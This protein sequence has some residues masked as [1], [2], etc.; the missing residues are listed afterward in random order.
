MEQ[1]V[2]AQCAKAKQTPATVERLILDHCVASRL[3]EL[4]QCTNLLNL[5]IINAGLHSL[6]GFP[7]LPR[8]RTVRQHVT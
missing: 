2:L 8:L 6:E 3:Q 5:S 4:A 1:S 7:S